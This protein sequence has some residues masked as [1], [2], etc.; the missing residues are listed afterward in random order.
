MEFC[1]EIIECGFTKPLP[2]LVMEDKIAL[3]Q[4][5]TLHHVLLRSKAEIDQFSEGLK[6]LGVL[7]AIRNY[8]SLMSCFFINKEIQHLTAGLTKH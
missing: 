1:T 8:P 4:T 6:A 5:L 7:D 2:C 3:I